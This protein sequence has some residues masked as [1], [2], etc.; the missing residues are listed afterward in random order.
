MLHRAWP[1]R[2][3]FRAEVLEH[4]SRPRL[5]DVHRAL[6][7]WVGIRLIPGRMRDSHSPIREILLVTLPRQLGRFVAVDPEYGVQV[8]TR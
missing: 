3:A 5:D 4:H 2:S 6:C 8:E 1:E 7:A